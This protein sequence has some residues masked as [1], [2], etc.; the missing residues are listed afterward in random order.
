MKILEKEIG[1]REE[2]RAV[3]Q[4]REAVELDAYQGKTVPLAQ[5]QDSLATRV[6]DVTIKVRELPEGAVKFGK[7]IALLTLVE[8]VMH[9]AYGLL[10]RPH[11]GPETIAAETEAIE[12]LLQAKRIK[13]GGGGGGGASPGGGG[14]GDTQESALALI[15]RGDDPDAKIE[16]RTVSQTTGVTGRQLPSEYRAGLDSYFNA[17]ESSAN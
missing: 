6:A 4:M 5:L 3:E 10:A 2:T 13:P 1:L 12:L 9:E 16:D 7:E 14:T 17:I 11:T 8:E 15:G